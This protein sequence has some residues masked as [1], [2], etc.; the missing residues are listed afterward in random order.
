[1]QRASETRKKAD[2]K[3]GFTLEDPPDG[4]IES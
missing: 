1:M 3:P 2:G 4:I